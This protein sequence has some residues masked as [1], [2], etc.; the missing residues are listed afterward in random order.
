MA[1]WQDLGLKEQSIGGFR[2]LYESLSPVDRP[3]GALSQVSNLIISPKGTLATRPGLTAVGAVVG[4]AAVNGIFPYYNT[5]AGTSQL[6]AMFGTSL[7]Q[8]NES[9][10]AWGTSIAT[11]NSAQATSVNINDLLLIFEQNTPRS[12]NGTALS[13]LGG[14]PPAGNL[15]TVAYSQVFVAGV[16]ATPGDGYF[17]D[18]ALPTVWAAAA[19]NNAGSITMTSREGDCITWVDF[20]KVLGKVLFWTRYALLV[21]NGPDTPNRPA[22]WNPRY[23]AP[24]GTPQGRTVKNVGGVWIWLTDK[25]FARWNGGNV[26][27]D[28]QPIKTTFDTID[29]ANIANSA[30]WIDFQGRYCCCVPVTGGAYAWLCYDKDYGWFVG[31]GASIRAGGSY[32]FDGLETPLVGTSDGYLRSV[33]GT[34]DAGTAIAWSAT[35]GPSFLGDTSHKKELTEIYAIMSLASGATATADVSNAETGAY[36]TAKTVSASTTISQMRLPLP[37]AAAEATRSGLFRVRLSGA[38]VASIYDLALSYRKAGR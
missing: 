7:R 31:T 4:A 2:G 27:L 20:D 3:L 29:W 11:L 22:L 30:A 25:G 24:Y 35:V 14:S 32:R 37:F 10:L 16:A 12:W 28:Y 18:D 26:Q 36:G 23:V 17:C 9:T 13:N 21:L 15:A 34:T 19:T 8:Y 33:E 5:V 38:G 6:L 1:V